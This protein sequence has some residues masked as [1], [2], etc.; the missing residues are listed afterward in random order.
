MSREPLVM[1]NPP[2]DA[3]SRADRANNS[4]P[5]PRGH[6]DTIAARMVDHA[7]AA[8]SRTTIERECVTRARRRA[9]G[10]MSKA[11]KARLENRHVSDYYNALVWS[12]PLARS[13]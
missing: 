4:R 2:L 11:H 6:A 12:I 7:V 8:M 13:F 10:L 9:N 3:S 1:S 5:C